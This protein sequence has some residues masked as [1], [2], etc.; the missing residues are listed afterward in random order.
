MEKENIIE[1]S[2]VVI[3]SDPLESPKKSI[4]AELEFEREAHE[5]PPTEA[6]YVI[7]A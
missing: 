6:F 7:T 2:S 3:G 5:S 1:P 4:E